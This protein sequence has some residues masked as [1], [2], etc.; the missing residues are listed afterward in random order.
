[1]KS[2]TSKG[3]MTATKKVGNNEQNTK[4]LRTKSG[5]TSGG[6]GLNEANSK[7]TKKGK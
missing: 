4:Y 3:S 7:Y 1:M 5:K 6:T 2:K